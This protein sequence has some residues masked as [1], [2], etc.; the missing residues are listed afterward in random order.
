MTNMEASE[1]R[2]WV[3][4]ATVYSGMALILATE[5]VTQLGF[6]HGFLYI[7]LLVL[8]FYAGGGGFLA[9]VT[10]LAVAAIWV[11]LLLSPSGPEGFPMGYVV[12][13]RLGAT[14]AVLAVFSVFYYYQSIFEHERRR[15]ESL[16]E[17]RARYE[18]IVDLMPIQIWTS[19][20]DGELDYIGGQFAQF[21]GTTK[22][23]FLTA[24]RD[25]L[26][27]DDRAPTL[28]H[29]GRSMAT[30]EPYIR[31]VRLRRADGKYIWHL[32]QAL[33]VKSADGGILRWVGL[34]IDITGLRQLREEAK[35]LDLRLQDTVESI[36]DAFFTVNREYWL[37]YANLKAR[38]LLGLLGGPEEASSIWGQGRF[39]PSDPFG[40]QFR[41]AMRRG[42]AVT[43]QAHFEPR[44]V[45]LDVRIYPLPDGLTVYLLDVTEE[46]KQQQELKLLRAAISRIND[47]VLITE[48]EPIEYPGPRI[49]FANEA[50]ERR[51]GYTRDEAIG[52]TPRML[53]GPGT[54]PA[55][56]RRIRRALEQWRPVRAELLNYTKSGEE[57][58][59]ELDIVPLAD[60]TGWFTHWVSVERDVTAKRA[61]ER[62]LMNAQRMEATGRLTGGLAHDFNNLL[63]VILGNVDRLEEHVTRGSQPARL[64]RVIEQ[65]AERGRNL[66]Q[67][68]LAFAR[69]QTLMPERLDFQDLL[70]E[71]RPILEASLGQQSR[72]VIL[73]PNE[74]I[75]PVHMDRSQL[76]SALLNLA[77]NA[78]D[79]MPEGGVL[80]I[81]MRNADGDAA[82]GAPDA[83]AGDGDFLV[84]MVRDTGTGMY[85]DELDRIFEPFFSGK[86]TG[87]G[88][89]L[90]LSMVF[91]FLQQS[92]GSIQVNSEP[93]SG[94]TFTLLL[95]ASSEPA[96][97]IVEPVP[98]VLDK[99]WGQVILIV[100]DHPEIL[101]LVTGILREAGFQTC[102]AEDA[103]TAIEILR[104]DAQLDLLL[105]DVVLPGCLSGTDVVAQACEVRPGLPIVMASGYTGDEPMVGNPS[106]SSA[107]VLRKPYRKAQLLTAIHQALHKDR[108]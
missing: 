59:L 14:A 69:R 79:A 75:L 57:L 33:P 11:G 40:M 90:G 98:D 63:T 39:S 76:E 104:S 22:E 107:P 71:M 86:A 1:P 99:G 17:E 108:G 23:G 31:E 47:I 15:L 26:H 60:E 88:S 3:L 24:W 12:A 41:R 25:T 96:D 19:R 20:P 37:T 62:E 9:L 18:Q 82:V 81:G 68:L 2:S 66:T 51:T 78:A 103:D 74:S 73:T 32:A 91:G 65:A 85:P 93:G 30:G 80:E 54:Q 48:A 83:D 36:T 64:L 34:A 102:E 58:W 8:A 4:A 49:I 87:Q 105:C 106:G 94:T 28:D 55:E 38:S 7:P 77:F 29:W 89:G 45:C 95:P 35:A 53:Q 97:L 92:G 13:N 101:E 52:N 43:F 70:E 61:M 67:S 50:F 44:G 10:A 42:E 5:W 100:E 6:A 56:L 21:S 72:L 84:V 46:R 27:P 16:R